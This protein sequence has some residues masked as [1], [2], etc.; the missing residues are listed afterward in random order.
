MVFS[1]LVLWLVFTPLARARGPALS[2]GAASAQSLTL[3]PTAFLPLV[4]V[5]RNDIR[6]F[7]VG[8]DPAGGEQ[9]EHIH[10]INCGSGSV[11]VTGW[12]VRSP[13]TGDVFV[14]PSY[15]ASP[16]CSGQNQFT[17]NTHVTGFEDASKGLFTWNQPLT[18]EEWPNTGGAAELY[19]ASSA[20]VMRCTYS[21]ADLAAPGDAYCR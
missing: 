9:F 16:G 1:V 11:D 15:I 5:A 20:L 3:T 6:I 2:G 8:Y 7:L 10:L 4:L 17:V 21:P 18:R 14:F 12:Q 19:D 13:F